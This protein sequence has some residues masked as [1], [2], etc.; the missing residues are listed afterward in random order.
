M[1]SH[2]PTTTCVAT[3]DATDGAALVSVFQALGSSDKMNAS[4]SVC[5]WEGVGR[6][7]DAMRQGAFSSSSCSRSP[8]APS[9]PSLAC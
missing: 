7:S 5:Q 4:V 9:Q 6:A 8:R 3:D 1:P 2:A